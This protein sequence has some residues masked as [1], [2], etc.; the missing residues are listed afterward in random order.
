MYGKAA[1]GGKGATKGG[2][3][4]PG[5]ASK[6][7]ASN[8]KGGPAASIYNGKGAKSGKFGG[9]P[10]VVPAMKPRPG[11][12]AEVSKGLGR[13]M[14]NGVKR[15]A[16]A[17]GGPGSPEKRA[18]TEVASN[19]NKT[20]LN[21]MCMKIVRRPLT[22]GEIQ[23]DTQEV[24]DGALRG[25]Q[26]T[27]SCASLPGEWA[28]TFFTGEVCSAAKEAEENAA[29]VAISELQS[30]PELEAAS[31]IPNAD[32]R[33]GKGAKGGKSAGSGKGASAP[34]YPP[35][36]V[37][38]Q[39]STHT[40]PWQSAPKGGKSGK[41]DKGGMWMWV[42]ENDYG[43]SP[44]YG[45]PHMDWPAPTPW[46]GKASGKGKPTLAKG[47]GKPAVAVAA[48]PLQDDALNGN[49][50]KTLLNTAIMKITKLPL[51]K[52]SLFTTEEI[53]GGYMS[54]VTLPDHFPATDAGEY[55]GTAYTGDVCPDTKAAEQSAAQATLEAILADP[56]LEALHRQ[57]K[58]CTL[59]KKER[60]TIEKDA[61][62][63]PTGFAS[64]EN[65][66]GK[67][68]WGPTPPAAP[69]QF[70]GARPP[71]NAPAGSNETTHKTRLNQTCMRIVKRALVKGE[72]VYSTQQV[73]G[74]HQSEVSAPFLPGDT[75]DM[76]FVGEVC[77]TAKEAEQTAA[78]IALE[79]I[80]ADGELMAL[81][82][83]PSEK[84]MA[85]GFGKGK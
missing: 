50:H 37:G 21:T 11:G 64:T 81:H 24:E 19:S 12:A 9:V 74:G 18:K 32:Q 46:Y 36:A 52:G 22:K 16:P 65:G 20:T 56:E 23:F 75:A 29:S 31:K 49:N 63:P 85:K 1:Y 35:P 6:G 7:A 13:P 27:I 43:P 61:E 5:M 72:I 34:L 62:V 26:T 17:G 8:F 84:K 83:T 67:G 79:T 73:E 82:D 45:G 80:L 10:Q 25:F 47:K 42:P 55:A 69:P 15:P 39:A 68:Q 59:K 28:E 57:P 44:A 71:A 48:A 51:S 4:K 30:D 41:G 54:T 58:A 3:G 76:N 33:K 53:D 60:S 77:A 14:Q 70:K 78:G 2:F 38:W 66:K 40:P